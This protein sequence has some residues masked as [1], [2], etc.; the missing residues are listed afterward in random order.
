MAL[1]LTPLIDEAEAK[2]GQFD[3]KKELL[4]GA[5][6]EL[7]EAKA[8]VVLAQTKVDEGLASVNTAGTEAVAAINAIISVL[9]DKVAELQS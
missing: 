2:L 3:E 6:G 8:A 1:E 4:V 7:D 9:Q 5:R